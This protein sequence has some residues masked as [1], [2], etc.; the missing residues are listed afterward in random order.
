MTDCPLCV[1]GDAP[2]NVRHG[3]DPACSARST[4]LPDPPAPTVRR[5][6]D[7]PTAYQLADAQL[8]G[9]PVRTT[10]RRSTP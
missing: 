1:A 10:D 2:E 9:P 8:G 7:R 5:L 3:H 6:P 4:P